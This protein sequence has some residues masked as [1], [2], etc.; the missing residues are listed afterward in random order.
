MELAM[1]LVVHQVA[2]EAVAAL[3]PLALALAARDKDLANQ[4][5]RAAASILLN[6]AEGEGS[7]PGNARSRF[8]TALGSTREVRAALCI[9]VAWG[10]VLP[11]DQVAVD[12]LLDRTSAML[13]RL[14]HPLRP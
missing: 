3:R 4:L 12:V 10:H 6:I 9:A 5:R 13:Y 1:P 14:L 2:A 7:D 11:A 8:H